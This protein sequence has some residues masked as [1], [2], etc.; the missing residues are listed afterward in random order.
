MTWVITQDNRAGVE[1]PDFGELPGCYPSQVGSHSTDADPAD[2]VKTLQLGYWFRVRSNVCGCVG[3]VGK[4]WPVPDDV[5]DFRVT[6]D[7]SDEWLTGYPD[8]RIVEILEP[9]GWCEL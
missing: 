7:G 3:L 4:V 5:V 6:V 9:W 2:V 1:H 8:L